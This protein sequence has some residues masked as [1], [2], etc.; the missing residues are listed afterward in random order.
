MF[1][2]K[3]ITTMKIIHLSMIVLIMSLGIATTGYSQAKKKVK[4]EKLDC[5]S[6]KKMVEDAKLHYLDGDF[7][8]AIKILTEG[9]KI[10]KVVRCADTKRDALN[11]LS[12]LYLFKNEDKSADKLFRKSLK[13]DPS[14]R[15]NPELEP[16]DFLY[17]ADRYKAVP[18]LSITPE[19]SLLQT[20]P[21]NRDIY[22]VSAVGAGGYE[23]SSV[24]YIPIT[25]AGGSIRAS[26]HLNRSWEISGGIGFDEK[27]FEIEQKQINPTR[28][29]LN[30]G[31]SPTLIDPASEF[32]LI[33]ENQTWLSTPLMLKFNFGWDNLQFNVFGGYEPQW[34]NMARFTKARRGGFDLL[35][36]INS[37]SGEEPG[38]DLYELE[39]QIAL[40]YLLSQGKD[41][42]EITEEELTNARNNNDIVDFYFGEGVK[43]NELYPD[44]RKNKSLFDV[45]RLRYTY[46][47]AFIVGGGFKYRPPGSKRHYLTFNL[48]YGRYRYDINESYASYPIDYSLQGVETDSPTSLELKQNLLY[49]LGYLDSPFRLHYVQY[50][51]GYAF[52]IY[53]VKNTQ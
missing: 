9:N 34:L 14:Y 10:N 50:S 2:V 28:I 49:A 38:S 27:I 48:K 22:T 12:K 32:L 53:R 31:L 51:I 17:F 43:P 15:L 39:E 23:S 18:L 36:Q 52:Q 40:A 11:L 5:T 21:Y 41:L 4:K 46:N 1:G 30:S 37:L 16:T 19:V 6:L 3:N 7:A 33:R 8:K 45:K 20:D 29:Y 13:I 42:F 35:E 24:K 47:P 26:F 25:S 44:S